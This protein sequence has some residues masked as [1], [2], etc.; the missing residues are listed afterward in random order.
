MP[1]SLLNLNNRDASPRKFDGID[2]PIKNIENSDNRLN[3]SKEMN[4]K[5]V[6]P[7]IKNKKIIEANER[8]MG[9][10]MTLPNSSIINQKSKF[11]HSG[12][13]L[14]VQEAVFLN[15]SFII[16]STL[17]ILVFLPIALILYASYQNWHFLRSIPLSV[18]AN[19]SQL[20]AASPLPKTPEIILTPMLAKLDSMTTFSIQSTFNLEHSITKQAFNIVWSGEARRADN[21]LN[22]MIDNAASWYVKDNEYEKSLFNSAWY[23]KDG[24]LSV[25]VDQADSTDYFKWGNLAGQTVL[26]VISPTPENTESR[27]V[28]SSPGEFALTKIRNNKF[29]D[30]SLKYANI[31]LDNAYIDDKNRTVGQNYVIFSKLSKDDFLEFIKEFINIY[32]ESVSGQGLSKS[33]LEIFHRQLSTSLSDI[34]IQIFVNVETL[35]F[36]NLKIESKF[37]THNLPE[38]QKEEFYKYYENSSYYMIKGNLFL[39]NLNKA[40]I[41]PEIKQGKPADELDWLTVVQHPWLT[42][43]LNMRL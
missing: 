23:F 2:R 42:P 15:K 1:V 29:T 30:L 37:F 5:L 13:L 19:I 10:N 16:G 25:K 6:P 3:I 21:N 38:F 7:W 4:I 36:D 8:A 18:R 40:V 35:Q 24:I 12:E 39:S 33:E 31:L 17:V 26:F 22:F 9:A 11:N 43:L 14:S 32:Q 27:G 28:R 41:I 34:E 20:I